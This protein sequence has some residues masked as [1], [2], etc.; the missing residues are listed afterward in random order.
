VFMLNNCLFEP[1]CG[2]LQA[3]RFFCRVI[4]QYIVV[5]LEKISILTLI[6]TDIQTYVI[7]NLVTVDRIKWIKSSNIPSR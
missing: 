3:V 7:L 2:H 4:C 1:K 6:H 5:F